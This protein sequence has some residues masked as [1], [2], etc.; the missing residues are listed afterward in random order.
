MI[1]VEEISRTFDVFNVPVLFPYNQANQ[2]LKRNEFQSRKAAC[3]FNRVVNDALTLKLITSNKTV[4][5]YD[6]NQYQNRQTSLQH[7]YLILLTL[8]PLLNHFQTD[9]TEF[10]WGNVLWT[11]TQERRSTKLQTLYQ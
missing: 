7:Y 3:R 1:S 8:H 5:V 9:C 6:V 4:S 11:P 2:P 10:D